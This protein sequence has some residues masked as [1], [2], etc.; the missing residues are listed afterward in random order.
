MSFLSL[1]LAVVLGHALSAFTISLP[2]CFPLLCSSSALTLVV[3]S[4]HAPL[5]SASLH[6]L[7]PSVLPSSLSLFL[8]LILPLPYPLCCVSSGLSQNDMRVYRIVLLADQLAPNTCMVNLSTIF[9]RKRFSKVAIYNGYDMQS[10]F[11]F[12]GNK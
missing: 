8:S 7:S 10:R 12:V 4:G 5:A 9:E 1:T 3:V 11:C 2:L 6:H